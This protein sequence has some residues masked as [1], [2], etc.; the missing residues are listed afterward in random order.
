MKVQINLPEFTIS[1]QLGETSTAL[2]V[3]EF[4]IFYFLFHE[5]QNSLSP[6]ALREKVWT[7]S[8]KVG[9]QTLNVHLNT[10]RRKL[11]KIG[12]RILLCD[13]CGDGTY[14]LKF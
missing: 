7:K 8:V 11:S 12:I 5:V 10:L 6:A 13:C 1:N 2:T 9:K 4:Q 3:K 14:K